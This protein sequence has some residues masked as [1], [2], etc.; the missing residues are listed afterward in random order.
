MMLAPSPQGFFEDTPENCVSLFH[1]IFGIIGFDIGKIKSLPNG[2]GRHVID[3][4]SKKPRTELEYCT[5]VWQKH[6]KAIEAK[7]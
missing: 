7:T 1:F 2:L 5:I 4:Y 6:L 3:E